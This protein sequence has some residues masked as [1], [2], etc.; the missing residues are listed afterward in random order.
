MWPNSKLQTAMFV[1]LDD[2]FYYCILM[3]FLHVHM[4]SSHLPTL[5][6]HDPRHCVATGQLAVVNDPLVVPQLL[7]SHEISEARDP[8]HSADAGLPVCKW[9]AHIVYIDIY[10]DIYWYIIYNMQTMMLDDVEDSVAVW[11][12]LWFFGFPRCRNYLIHVG[13]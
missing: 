2:W 1:N 10:I 9:Y 11:W 12:V 3:Y 4:G 7:A 8:A 6:D 13:E 5:A